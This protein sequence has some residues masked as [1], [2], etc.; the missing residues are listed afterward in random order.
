MAMSV[1]E[2]VAASV[3]DRRVWDAYGDQAAPG[4]YVLGVPGRALPF[5]VSRA[6]K[7]PTGTVIEEIRLIGPSGRT[8]HRWGPAPRRMRGMM[9]LTVEVDTLD[10]AVLDETGTF[11]ASFIIDDVIVG[12]TEFPVYLQA[13]PTSLPKEVEDGFKRSDVI[14]LGVEHQGRRTTV[15]SWFAYKDGKVFVLSQKEPGPDEQTVPGIPN[16]KELVLITR[17]KLRDTALGEYYATFRLLEGAEWEAAAKLLADKRKSRAGAPNES[18][19]RWRTTCHIA[20]LTP[21]VPGT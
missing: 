19:A 10:D 14:W 13:S 9:D 18:I 12:E 17:R 11:V 4:V 15:P 2:L 3:V 1:G 21:V 20:E 5:V 8:V 6:W 7:V 16:A